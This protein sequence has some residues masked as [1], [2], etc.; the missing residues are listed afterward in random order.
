MDNDTNNIINN[1]KDLNQVETTI[2]DL[3][4]DV[5]L[6][7][8]TTKPLDPDIGE[9]CR[10][11]TVHTECGIS[12]DNILDGKTETQLTHPVF[13]GSVV[14]SGNSATGELIPS[15]S[16]VEESADLNSAIGETNA[17]QPLDGIDQPQEQPQNFEPHQDELVVDPIEDTAKSTITIDLEANRPRISSPRSQLGSKIVRYLKSKPSLV[18]LFTT[19][20]FLLLLAIPS[21]LKARQRMKKMKRE[22]IKEREIS[23]ISA[24]NLTETL[25]QMEKKLEELEKNNEEEMNEIKKKSETDIGDVKG[26]ISNGLERLNQKMQQSIEEQDVKL[27]TVSEDSQGIKDSIIQRDIKVAEFNLQLSSKFVKYDDQIDCLGQSQNKLVE[28]VNSIDQ[29]VKAHSEI[30]SKLE[31]SS[32]AT[33]Q[34]CSGM[35][36][37]IGLLEAK[38]NEI[39]DKAGGMDTRLNDVCEETSHFNSDLEQLNEQIAQFDRK[40]DQ[41]AEDQSQ[42]VNNISDN[43]HNLNQ[44]VSKLSSGVVEFSQTTTKAVNMLT[45]DLNQLDSN[46]RQHELVTNDIMIKLNEQSKDN[47]NQMSKM[48]SAFEGKVQHQAVTQ[49]K[50]VNFVE[51]ITPPA[52]APHNQLNPPS[53]ANGTSHKNSLYNDP[54]TSFSESKQSFKAD[55]IKKDEIDKLKKLNGD[56]LERNRKRTS[57]T[58]TKNNNF[59]RRK[60]LRN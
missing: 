14:T 54:Q 22:L 42:S 29:Q 56:F 23:K 15:Q 32:D 21:T 50:L 53:V 9:Y 12:K 55:R 13:D 18:I 52:T 36:G 17:D 1:T 10:D 31:K 60:F 5:N 2:E 40:H 27:K 3:P 47:I 24:S 11:V 49:D 28:Q 7:S 46:F 26:E 19:I 43:I 20:F 33:D 34:A 59:L 25:T 37:S 48:V 38:V 6:I 16:H 51:S 4:K 44:E 45:N 8:D 30:I 58:A 57:V 39:E 35:A 41:R